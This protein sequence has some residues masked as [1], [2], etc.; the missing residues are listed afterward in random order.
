[1]I[2]VS[3]FL[4]LSEIGF[5]DRFKDHYLVA[6]QST[7]FMLIALAFIYDA[8]EVG[9][10]FLC[11]LFIVFSFS[12]LGSTPPHTLVIWTAMTIV[13]TGLFLL[14][15]KPTSIPHAT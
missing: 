3:V 7:A 12:S 9:G 15:D 10:M 14:T 13:L 2:M 1:M 8:P 6:P 5:N 4:L 11:T